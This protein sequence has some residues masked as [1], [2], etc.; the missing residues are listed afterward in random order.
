MPSF[1]FDGLYPANNAII[2]LL[3]CNMVYASCVCT[4]IVQLQHHARHHLPTFQLI[5][6][7]V[8]ESLV[9][10]PIM[11][12]ILFF[13][14]E[15]YDDQLLLYRTPKHSSFGIKPNVPWKLAA[16]GGDRGPQQIQRSVFLKFPPAQ[17]P[18]E[19]FGPLWAAPK[20]CIPSSVRPT[21][22]ASC[23]PYLLEQA[24][25]ARHHNNVPPSGPHQSPPSPSNLLHIKITDPCFIPLHSQN[26]LSLKMSATAVN[27]AVF[28]SSPYSSQARPA[29]TRVMASGG[30]AAER[31][32]S[33]YE[34]LR[35]KETATIT[36][37]KSAYRSLAKRYH[38]DVNRVGNNNGS[39]FVEIQGA[40]ATLSD[41]EAKARHD[42]TAVGSGRVGSYSGSGFRGPSRRWET[43]QCW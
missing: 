22:A 32:K 19:N 41:P 29:K 3:V 4:L 16:R 33:P 28:G 13:L 35:V 36:E 27:F 30:T 23:G 34:V 5:F 40:Y 43:D 7:H 39:E 6:V 26:P 42:R 15:F 17:S 31:K 37:I 8:I 38:P 14:F 9:F 18:L 11:I 1:V 25:L 2:K 21:A 12:G 20:R 24:Q 10:V